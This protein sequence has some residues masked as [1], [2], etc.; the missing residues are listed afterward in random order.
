LDTSKYKDAL[1]RTTQELV[2]IPSV[3]EPPAGEGKPFGGPIALALEYTLA[4]GRELGFK[5]E[6]FSGYAGHIEYGQGPETVG[7]LCHLDVVPAGEGWSVNPFGGEIIDDKIYGRGTIDNK[8]PAVAALYALAALKDSG[9]Q[10]RRRVRIILGTDEESGWACMDHYMKVADKP[11]LG[12]APD[13][14]FPVINS[15]KGILHVELSGKLQSPQGITLREIQ[16]GNRPNMVPDRCSVRLQ[17]VEAGQVSAL[18]AKLGARLDIRREEEGIALVFKGVSAHGST[19]ES[20]ENAISYA[21]A[22][23]YHLGFED[24]IIGFL[25]QQI[26][27][28]H[29][30]RGLNIEFRDAVSGALTVNLGVIGM[31]GDTVKAV[32]DIRYPVSCTEGQVLAGISSVLPGHI[33][34][35]S[36]GGKGPLHVEADSELIKILQR[37]YEKHTGEEAELISIGGGTYARALDNGVAFGPVFPGQPELAHQPDEFISIGHLS[38]LMAIYADAIS[39]LADMGGE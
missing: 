7:I 26:G 11:H 9:W 39:K 16:G 6:N 13:A 4:K 29:D 36:Q 31:E 19:P 27:F 21:L 15:E 12:F 18:A 14:E 23:L 25:S 30:G 2:R 5:T 35:V 34:L 33:T 24:G 37:V 8:G 32:L 28:S 17:G 38:K 10:P 20:G 22:L 1:I 3:K